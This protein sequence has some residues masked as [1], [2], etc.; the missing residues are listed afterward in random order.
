MPDEPC[1]ILRRRLSR[2]E[3]LVHSRTRSKSEIHA[4]LQPAP[5]ALV[6]LQRDEFD[7]LAN[8]ADYRL[9][10]THTISKSCSSRSDVIR[11]SITEPRLLLRES[12]LAR[13]A[14]APSDACRLL[15]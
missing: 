10:S 1:R 5:Q 11:R 14:I 9:A 4:C 8:D 13:K 3:Q 2:C 15:C 7:V 6:I 12:V